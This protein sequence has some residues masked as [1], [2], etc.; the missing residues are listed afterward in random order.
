[1]VTNDCERA[2]VFPPP[3]LSRRSSSPARTTRGAVPTVAI[4]RGRGLSWVSAHSLLAVKRIL[5]T[6]GTVAL[7]LVGGC[8]AGSTS[9]SRASESAES[10]LP[11]PIETELTMEVA[12]N[13][14]GTVSVT[15]KSNLPNGTELNAS[16]L[17]QGT[18][19]AQDSASLQYGAVEFGPFSNNGAP[20]PAGTYQ[21]SVTMPIA[22]NQPSSVQATIGEHGEALTGPQVS[23]ESVTDDAVVTTS[24]ELVIP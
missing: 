20:L 15:A 11:T 23:K 3:G 22:R 10:S 13:A 5:S 12:V 1:M 14:D 8:S 6:V 4:W 21:V 7:L 2:R 18:F 24:Q 16:V 9:G 19:M 17:A